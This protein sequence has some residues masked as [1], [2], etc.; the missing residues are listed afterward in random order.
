MI[1]ACARAR[2]FFVLFLPYNDFYF[3]LHFELLYNAS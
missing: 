1:Q 2:V 3:C